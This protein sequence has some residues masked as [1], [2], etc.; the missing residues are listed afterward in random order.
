MEL[1]KLV[2]DVHPEYDLRDSLNFEQKE[3]AWFGLVAAL[4]SLPSIEKRN[5]EFDKDLTWAR[6]LEEQADNVWQIAQNLMTNKEI[7][8]GGGSL[9]GLEL[10]FGA[11]AKIKAIE[12]VD[13]NVEQA[14]KAVVDFLHDRKNTLLKWKKLSES[15]ANVNF[16]VREASRDDWEFKKREFQELL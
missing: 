10:W 16:D 4:D 9:V 15:R 3:E 1:S 6:T 11:I 14:G 12:N 8:K 2:D 13:A 7:G 5:N